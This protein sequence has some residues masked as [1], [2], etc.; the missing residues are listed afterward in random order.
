MPLDPEIKKQLAPTGRAMSNQVL[1]HLR[2]HIERQAKGVAEVRLEGAQIRFDTIPSVVWEET[3]KAYREIL[4]DP[5]AL[6]ALKKE[7]TA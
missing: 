3:V 1:K 6:E 7:L 4:D 2:S 5:L